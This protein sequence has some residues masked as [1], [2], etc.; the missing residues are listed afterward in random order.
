MDYRL[1][2]ALLENFQVQVSA[3]SHSWIVDEPLELDGDDLGPNPF[4]LMLAALGS[5]MAITL[6]HYGAQG[7][8]PVEKSESSWLLPTTSRPQ[9][10]SCA[11]C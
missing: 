9:N 11:C 6:A 2:C 8:I 7:K 3:R 10:S 4:E 1:T 5:C